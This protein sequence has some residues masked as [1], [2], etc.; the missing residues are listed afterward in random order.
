MR[1][2]AAYEPSPTAQ[3]F[4]V[5]VSTCLRQCMPLPPTSMVRHDWKAVEEV[6]HDFES[7]AGMHDEVGWRVSITVPLPR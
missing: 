5:D 1:R 4:F 3:T 6:Y 2:V 7:I